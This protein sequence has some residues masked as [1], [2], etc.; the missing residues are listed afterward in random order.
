MSLVLVGDIGGTNLRYKLIY[1]TRNEE[2]IV[3]YSVFP[4]VEYQSNLIGS[5]KEFLSDC[6]TPA[7][8]VIGISG[9]VVNNCVIASL[10]YGAGFSASLLTSELLIPQAF[11]LNDVEALCYSLFALAPSELTE[12]N[13]AQPEPCGPKVCVAIGTGI[14][15]CYCVHNGRQYQVHV[16]EGGRLDCSPKTQADSRLFEF[17]CRKHNTAG[18][19]YKQIVSGAAAGGLYEHFRQEKPEWVEKRVDE[20][21]MAE[22]NT[23]TEKM[24][25][26]GFG[27]GDRI[28]GEAVRAWQRIVGNMLGNVFVNFLPTG[29]IYLC[30]GVVAKNYEGIIKSKAIKEGFYLG[31]ANM[32]HTEMKK[33]PIFVVKTE[34]L[35]LKGALEYAKTKLYLNASE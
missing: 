9:L 3:K 14:G 8:A 31:R 30:G 10:H 7:M 33:I 1:V 28:A 29:G 23:R 21:V 4:A 17:L 12:I 24:M 26:V 15:Q 19:S 2:Q 6:E 20:E 18:L 5:L 13:A 34:E 16:S 11:V 35:G 22:E 25:R 32:L 27:K